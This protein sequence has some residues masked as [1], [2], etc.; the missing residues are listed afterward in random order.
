[1]RSGLLAGR[2]RLFPLFVVVLGM[3][4]LAVLSGC[5]SGNEDEAVSE[6]SPRALVP[7]GTTDST[8]IDTTA[9]ATAENPTEAGTLSDSEGVS[10]SMNPG[11]DSQPAVKAE[12]KPTPEETKSTAAA[13]D[14]RPK[15]SV[16]GSDG[17]YSLQLGSFTNPE[18]ARKQADRLRSMG[19]A[20]V[21][22]VS[23]LGGQTYHRVML[24]GVGDKEKASRLGEHIHSELG[25]AYLVRRGN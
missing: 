12:I 18:N 23:D 21:I 11:E 24:K 5:G 3:A 19:Y 22:D 10:G 9:A 25:I 14:T 2:R 7:T 20:P 15:T 16:T 1:M 4:A 13:A 17:A 6:Q 8:A